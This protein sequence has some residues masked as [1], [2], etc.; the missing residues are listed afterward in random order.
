LRR[1]GVIPIPT[2]TVRMEEEPRTW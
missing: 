1:I 2:V